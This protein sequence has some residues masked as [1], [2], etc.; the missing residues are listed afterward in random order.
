[1]PFQP[2]V[3]FVGEPSSLLLIAKIFKITTVK[4]FYRIGPWQPYRA[5]L[6]LGQNRHPLFICK[7]ASN[8]QVENVKHKTLPCG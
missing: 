2:S 8:T 7:A 4:G 6:E 5:V 3:M 1:M